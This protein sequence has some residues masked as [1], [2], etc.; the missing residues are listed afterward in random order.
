MGRVSRN[1]RVAL[2]LSG[3][4]AGMAGLSFASVPLYKLFCQVTGYGGTTQ[5]AERDAGRVIDRVITVRFN[6]DTARD[7][8]WAFRPVA[9][10][11]EV[12]VGETQ[13]AFYSASNR[14][15]ETITGTATF[16]VTPAKAG[17]YFD[18]IDC[19]CFTEQT[20]KPGESAELPV[21]FFIDPAIRDDKNLD[22]VKTI[23]LSY[24]FFRARAGEAP[25][26]SS[27]TRGSTV[28]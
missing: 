20:L 4:A 16:N 21:S 15:S 26:T 24:T 8:P 23:T 9:R 28:N 6:A 19:F 25:R 18:K 5:R 22:E 7:L 27:L 3:V 10:Q 13:L 12:R 11:I 17:L 1:G 2:V 14:S